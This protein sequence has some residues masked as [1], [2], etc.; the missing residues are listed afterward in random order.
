MVEFNVQPIQPTSEDYGSQSK[1]RSDETNIP[2]IRVS[3]LY[4]QHLNKQ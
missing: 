2:I 4:I 1:N 3:F